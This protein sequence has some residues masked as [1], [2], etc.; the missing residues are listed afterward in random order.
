MM[1]FQKTYFFFWF[2]SALALLCLVLTVLGISGVSGI[3]VDINLACFG[4]FSTGAFVCKKFPYKLLG[5]LLP[6]LCVFAVIHI[7]C[8]DFVHNGRTFPAI[9]SVLLAILSIF[10]FGS[11]KG[12]IF[13]LA[14]YLSS[15]YWAMLVR[16]G[17]EHIRYEVLIWLIFFPLEVL[18]LFLMEDIREKEQEQSVHMTQVDNLTGL[19]NRSGFVVET[20]QIISTKKKGYIVVVD[21]DHFQGI[22]LNLGSKAAD[23]ILMKI[24]L[25]ISEMNSTHALC[26]SYGDQFTW[27]S[28]LEPDDITFQF[29]DLST[30]IRELEKD[31]EVDITLTI[32]GGMVALNSGED[33]QEIWSHAE[34]AM[35]KAK[36]MKKSGLLMFEESFLDA[37]RRKE[38]I[39]MELDKAL[40]NEVIQVHFQ[41]KISMNTQ[42][43]VGMEALVRWIHPDL[44]FIPPPE[45][46]EAAESTGK[47]YLLGNY[48]LR[49]S[50]IHLKNVQKDFPE[51]T[52]S[53][54]ISA[55]QL[56]YKSFFK[57]L[58]SQV[59]EFD[60]SPVQVYLEVTESLFIRK[61]VGALLHQIRDEGFRLSLDD[62]GTGYS[63]MNYLKNF[64][65]D[66]L[67]VDKSF[68]DGILGDFR[69]RALFGNILKL[70]VDLGMET[71][72]EGVETQEQMSVLQKMKTQ[73]IQGWFFSKALPPEEFID[74]VR[75][76]EYQHYFQDE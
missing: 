63:S 59:R 26:R 41:P 76:F 52:I 75:N 50:L 69:E 40:E 60:V 4:L 47:I 48:V 11:R 58:T 51:M 20:R 1:D 12:L 46:I 43:V 65:F 7:L 6:Q 73:E 34:M 32:S 56:L 16:G 44:G 29:H 22:N 55:Q 10:A 62:F 19:L 24:A 67:K 27:L 25:L 21:L 30:K 45:F 14:L 8:F 17:G 28:E 54:N 68:T 70:A 18:I 42:K 3:R 74:F 33:V 15:I 13:P 49:K 53:I 38:K 61:E 39:S 64:Y 9:E 2:N 23:E 36:K 37:A 71:V 57:E 66:E 72:I 5:V 31:S 35:E